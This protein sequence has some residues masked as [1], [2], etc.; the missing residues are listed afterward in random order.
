MDVTITNELFWQN[1]WNRSSELTK[2][3]WVK[4]QMITGNPH[5]N[6]LSDMILGLSMPEKAQ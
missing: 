4:G 1:G 3:S 6:I 5:C 2:L